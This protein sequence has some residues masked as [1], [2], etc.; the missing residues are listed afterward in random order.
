MKLTPYI[1]AAAVIMLI[2]SCND[3]KKTSD[4]T[5]VFSDLTSIQADDP[6]FA[7][8]DSLIALFNDISGDLLQIKH[9]ESIVTIP[10]NI[11]NETGKSVPQ[12]RDDLVAI[13][14]ALQE[15]RQRLS[16]LE[17]KLK[18]SSGKNAQL[19]QMVN[20]LKEQMTQNEQT[21]VS[22]KEQL[23]QA[24][25]TIAGLNTQIDSLNVSVANV[26][27]EKAIAEQK[28]T[29][30]TNEL[31]RCYYAIGSKDELKKHKLITTGFL[32]KTK[33]MQGDYESSYF[34]TA[35]KRTLTTIHL[36]SKKAKVLTNQPAD[37][38]SITTDANGNKILNIKNPEKFWN[39]ANY[40]IIQTD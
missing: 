22:L 2:A 3:K 35:D 7:E 18:N 27:E 31:N 23:A 20:N 12:L 1:S 14:N 26:T 10:G 34:T 15:R 9:V 39:T 33:I 11:N 36:Y 24:N 16:E 13:Q 30:L 25:T 28:N 29:E 5:D 32:R 19:L 6:V 8:R 17:Q 4:K 37:T 40:L 21:I 38:Y